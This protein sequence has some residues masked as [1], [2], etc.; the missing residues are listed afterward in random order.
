MANSNTQKEEIDAPEKRHH[1]FYFI[2]LGREPGGYLDVLGLGLNAGKGEIGTKEREFRQKIKKETKEKIRALNERLKSKEITKDEFNTQSEQYQEEQTRRLSEINDLKKGYE[3]EISQRRKNN[4]LGLADDNT[5][6]TT[7]LPDWGTRVE[8]L[9]SVL[10]GP[11][12]TTDH[13]RPTSAQKD[14]LLPIL[15]WADQC[16]SKI[17][18]TNRETWQRNLEQWEADIYAR[19]PGLQP[20]STNAGTPVKQPLFPKLCA[21]ADHSIDTLE[22]E[23]IEDLSKVPERASEDRKLSL[24]SLLAEMLE[25]ASAETPAKKLDNLDDPKPKKGLL[26]LLELLTASMDKKE[27]NFHNSKRD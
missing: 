1:E 22:K 20:V 26:E 7:T 18:W 23:E 5:V 11:H 9:C 8:R 3:E 16:W 24:A 19:V 6:W 2:T 27:T 17:K 4:N 15:L 21:A 12:V 10:L 25:K 13:L 14:P